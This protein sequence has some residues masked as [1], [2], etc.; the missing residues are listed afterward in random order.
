VEKISMKGTVNGLP[1]IHFPA[2]GMIH[3]GHGKHSARPKTDEDDR[4]RIHPHHSCGMLR[5]SHI[6]A[7][8]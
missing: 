6:A 8:A 7:E 1:V 2:A 3:P 5:H 4:I